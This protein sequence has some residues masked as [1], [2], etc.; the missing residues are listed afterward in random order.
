MTRIAK[1]FLRLRVCEHDAAL[2]V[3]NY[4]CIGRRFEKITEFLFFLLALAD[5]AIAFENRRRVS[6]GIHPQSPA[7]GDGDG[8]PI[9]PRVDQLAFPVAFLEYFRLNFRQGLWEDGVKKLMGNFSASLF[10][11]PAIQPLSC[12]IPIED[13]FFEA[14][15]KNCVVSEFEEFSV[16]AV[17]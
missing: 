13:F 10:L 17:H 16:F 14:A 1:Q 6:G 12:T 4:D 11:L 5:I 15:D 2:F 3:H 7:A 9:T 8:R